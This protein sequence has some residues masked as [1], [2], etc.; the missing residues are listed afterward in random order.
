MT[1][2]VMGM[3]AGIE[4]LAIALMLDAQEGGFRD[5]LIGGRCRSLRCC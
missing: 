2:Q 1:D 3:A 5:K 4:A